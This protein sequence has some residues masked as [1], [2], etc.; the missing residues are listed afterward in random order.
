MQ[1]IWDEELYPLPPDSPCRTCRCDKCSPD[2]YKKCTTWL[3]WFAKRWNDI[4][5]AASKAEKI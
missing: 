5:Q 2:Y 3:G 4:R 1:D